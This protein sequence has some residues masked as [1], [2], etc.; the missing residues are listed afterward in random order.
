MYF[1]VQTFFLYDLLPLPAVRPRTI[2]DVLEFHTLL[3]LEIPPDRLSFLFCWHRPLPDW[4]ASDQVLFRYIPR[5][6]K[7]ILNQS[8]YKYVLSLFTVFFLLACLYSITSSYFYQMKKR[9]I[10]LVRFS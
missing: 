9:T 8:Q 6:H 7:M 1:P 10:R 5:K 4:S 2:V 3:M